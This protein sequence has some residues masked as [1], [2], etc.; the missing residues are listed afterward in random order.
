[1][2]IRSLV[3]LNYA[4]RDYRCTRNLC[5]NLLRTAKNYSALANSCTL[6][7]DAFL[8]TIVYSQ[9]VQTSYNRVRKDCLD[10]YHVWG[11]PQGHLQG[12]TCDFFKTLAF[13]NIQ[14]YKCTC[15]VCEPVFLLFNFPCMLIPSWPVTADC[16]SILM[17]LCL[18]ILTANTP[19]KMDRTTTSLVSWL[20][21]LI[22][23]FS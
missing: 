16:W 15:V 5:C 3:T 8:F 13:F 18:I 22:K 14:G 7:T 17:I 20:G 2:L 21:V 10:R 9:N 11:T 1:M 12:P 23:R 4:C 19:T 6:Q